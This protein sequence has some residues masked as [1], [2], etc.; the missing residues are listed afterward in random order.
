MSTNFTILKT[1]ITPYIF[2]NPVGE[3]E[4]AYKDFLSLTQNY[5][6][7][8]VELLDKLKERLGFEYEIVIYNGSSAELLTAVKQQKADLAIADITITKERQAEGNHNILIFIVLIFFSIYLYF[9]SLQSTSL[10]H[11]C[12]LVQRFCIRKVRPR[13]KICFLSCNLFI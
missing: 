8:C 4:E 9:F 2:P 13:Q 11:F 6:G 3:D 5:T 1:Q 7:F 12:R 10:C